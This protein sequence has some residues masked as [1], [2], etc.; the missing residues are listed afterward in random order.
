MITSPST[1]DFGGRKI[2]PIKITR[3]WIRRPLFVS[4][5]KHR[6]RLVNLCFTGEKCTA[7]AQSSTRSGLAD[8][9]TQLEH[10]F[11]HYPTLIRRSH[12]L[13]NVLTIL[14]L[15]NSGGFLSR[16]LRF[17]YN[18]FQPGFPRNDLSSTWW[19][20]KTAPRKVYLNLIYPIDD[21]K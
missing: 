21:T 4:K 18:D 7:D 16:R 17:R 20:N 14:S 6:R 11:Q 2:Y 10:T 9:P 19:V 15:I 5:V 1:E 8:V 13:N 12:I 3:Y